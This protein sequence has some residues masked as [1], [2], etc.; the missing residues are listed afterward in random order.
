MDLWPVSV[1]SC[2]IYSMD[3]RLGKVKRVKRTDGF[4]S[5]LYPSL[6]HC[7]VPPHPTPG[8]TDWSLITSKAHLPLRNNL[9]QT[10]F[11]SSP[12]WS[13]GKS[14]IETIREETSFPWAATGVFDCTPSPPLPNPHHPAA[15]PQSRQLREGDRFHLVTDVLLKY[16]YRYKSKHKK[17]NWFKQFI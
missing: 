7:L 15:Q 17:R 2:S 11:G 4:R 13:P 5:H 6:Q 14:N 3:Q 9:D 1:P 8:L 10:F 12:K 16:E